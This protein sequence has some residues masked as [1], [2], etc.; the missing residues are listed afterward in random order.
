[1]MGGSY[2]LTSKKTKRTDLRIFRQKKRKKSEN[3]SSS[4]AGK[5]K[6]IELWNKLQD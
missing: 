1:M 3:L 5:E 2:E 4:S 6:L